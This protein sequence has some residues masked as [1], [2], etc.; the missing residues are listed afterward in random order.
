MKTFMRVAAVLLLCCLPTV[1][2]AADGFAAGT[3]LGDLGLCKED[4]DT[5]QSA[6]ACTAIIQ[7]KKETT[8]NLAKAYNYR[9][10]VYY[11]KDPKRALADFNEA[12][13]LN[14]TNAWFFIR[15]ANL[16]LGNLGLNDF[17]R[18]L[19][20]FTKV[21]ELRP[22][23]GYNYRAG[24]YVRKGDYDRA[25]ADYDQAVRLR[26]KDK[27]LL[28]YRADAYLGKKDFGG[29]IAAYDDLIK[30]DPTRAHSLQGR[31]YAYYEKGDYDR[32]I[33]DYDQAIQLQGTGLVFYYRGQ[34][35]AKTGNLNRA[36]ADY[37]QAIKID[38]GFSA[39]V[40][41]RRNAQGL[42]KQ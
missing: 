23:L 38:P 31:G 30:L 16:Y 15:R 3:D 24:V 34:A 12:V 2:F 26:P 18:A 25:V 10:H 22:D 33:A 36:I 17:D 7:A 21:I 37:D 6:R 1:G 40:I 14:P 9:G 27:L 41:A 32:A 29:A 8:A 42:L 20:D 5:D 19:A 13:R 4:G 39:A 11:L 35:Y 28:E